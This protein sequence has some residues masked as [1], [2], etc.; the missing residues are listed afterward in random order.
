MSYN[1]PAGHLELNETLAQ[2]ASRELL[3]KQVCP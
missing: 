3:K 2:A 1:Q